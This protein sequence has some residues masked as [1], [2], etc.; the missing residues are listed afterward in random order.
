M[1]EGGVTTKEEAPAYTDACMHAHTHAHTHTHTPPWKA[2]QL[3]S[4]IAFSSLLAGLAIDVGLEKKNEMSKMSR[5][6]F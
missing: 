1:R 4:A 5:T 6:P 3:I 2:A